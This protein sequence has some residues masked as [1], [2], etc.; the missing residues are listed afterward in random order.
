MIRGWFRGG[1]RVIW[2]WS[3]G[4]SN[5]VLECCGDEHPFILN[6]GSI[7]SLVPKLSM[8]IPDSGNPEQKPGM[9]LKLLH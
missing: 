5:V 9:L 4:G 2:R 7:G 3:E 6:F 8:D 1:S